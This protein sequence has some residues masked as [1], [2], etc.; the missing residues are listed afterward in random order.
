[1]VKEEETLN[2]KKVSLT[3]DENSLVRENPRSE[4]K[5]KEEAS[6]IMN[7]DDPKEEI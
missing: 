2:V 4:V 6:E 5:P 3:E 1:M 7:V